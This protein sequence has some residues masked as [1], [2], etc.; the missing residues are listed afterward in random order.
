MEVCG[1][2]HSFTA[3]ITC[4]ISHWTEHHG[5]GLNEP[6]SELDLD[7]VEIEIVESTLDVL[8]LD[9]CFEDI[10]QDIVEAVDSWEELLS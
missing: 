10:K 7:N 4:P 2:E 5:P 8:L 6:M 9:Q 1:A 3:K